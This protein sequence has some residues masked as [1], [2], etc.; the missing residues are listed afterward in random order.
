MLTRLAGLRSGQLS[1]SAALLVL[2]I[3]TIALPLLF[4]QY[5]PLLRLSCDSDR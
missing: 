3:L 4:F 5:R 1:V 2:G